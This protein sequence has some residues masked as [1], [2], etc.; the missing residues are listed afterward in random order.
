MAAAILIS[1]IAW[2]FC[3]RRRTGDVHFSLLFQIS[4]SESKR[5]KFLNLFCMFAGGGGGWGNTKL[6]VFE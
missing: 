1:L 5:R 6:R 3:K 4:L 2:Y